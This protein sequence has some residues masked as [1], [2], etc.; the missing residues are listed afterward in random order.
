[1]GPNNA[2]AQRFHFCDVAPASFQLACPPK[3]QLLVKNKNAFRKIDYFAT[4]PLYQSTFG[5]E[6]DKQVTNDWMSTFDSSWQIKA[7]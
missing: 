6:T 1:M 5:P 2:F 7:A 3:A 4:P